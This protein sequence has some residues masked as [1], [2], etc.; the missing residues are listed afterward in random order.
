MLTSK[1]YENRKQFSRRFDPRAYPKRELETLALM[2]DPEH[3]RLEEVLNPHSLDAEGRMLEVDTGL[4]VEQWARLVDTMRE[5]GIDVEILPGRPNLPDMVFSANEGFPYV[6]DSGQRRVVLSKMTAPSRRPEVAHF[7]GWFRARGFEVDTA[8]CGAGESF[9]GCGDLLWLS[10]RKVILGGWGFRTSRVVLDRL[11][12]R[13]DVPIIAF[14][15]TDPAF[16][17][18][19]T[20]VAVLDDARCLAHRPAFTEEGWDLLETVFEEVLEAPPD[21]AAKQLVCNAFAPRPGVVI[22]EEAAPSTRRLLED[23]GYE[24]RPV[25][26]SEFRKS[27]GSIFCLKLMVP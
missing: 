27:G 18:L 5:S 4:A 2:V 26:T 19:D 20:A 12:A 13:I 1:V 10:D 6:T 8:P 9:E 14:E 7:E 16:Y 21:E 23:K 25:P 17:H 24:V 22:L 15:L 11:A 3:F